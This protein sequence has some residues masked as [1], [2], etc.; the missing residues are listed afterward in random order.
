MTTSQPQYI[1]NSPASP[2]SKKSGKLSNSAL[3]AIT[4]ASGS[5]VITNITASTIA[6]AI[7]ETDAKQGSPLKVGNDDAQKQFV[8]LTIAIDSP[9]SGLGLADVKSGEAKYFGGIDPRITG[10]ITF[11]MSVKSAFQAS[12]DANTLAIQLL[13][14]FKSVSV[15][16]VVLSGGFLDRVGLGGKI[17]VGPAANLIADA[18]DAL[19]SRV[20]GFFSKLDVMTIRVPTV[21]LVTGTLQQT[22]AVTDDKGD[23]VD[24]TVIAANYFTCSCA[25]LVTAVDSSRANISC[26]KSTNT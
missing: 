7:K 25:D 9:L 11:G 6:T 19:S 22:F 10:A 20:T 15:D 8:W 21:P 18:L 4:H 23:K 13:P 3:A 16:H 14:A 26:M 5:N 12:D 1:R 17:D 2:S 24:M